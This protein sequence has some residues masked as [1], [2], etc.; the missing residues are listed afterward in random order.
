MF[1]TRTRKTLALEALCDPRGSEEFGMGTVNSP[2]TA[3]L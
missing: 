3:L 1:G 2:R